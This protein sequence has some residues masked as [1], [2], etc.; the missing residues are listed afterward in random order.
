MTTLGLGNKLDL[1]YNG[2]STRLSTNLDNL[3]IENTK[4]DDSI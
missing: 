4:E 2:T 1:V 3:T